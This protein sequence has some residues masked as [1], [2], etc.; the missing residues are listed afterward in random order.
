[1]VLVIGAGNT[2]THPLTATGE[3]LQPQQ[4]EAPAAPAVDTAA[5]HTGEA[6]QAVTTCCPV[7]DLIR[8]HSELI[9]SMLRDPELTETTRKWLERR[10]VI[11]IEREAIAV[12]RQDGSVCLGLKP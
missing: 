1:M 3:G 4:G 8:A 5:T 11:S 2:P 9:R 7:H 12:E 10:L 6:S